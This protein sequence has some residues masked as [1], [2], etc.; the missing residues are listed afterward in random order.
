M[1]SRR[2]KIIFIIS[3]FLVII[4]TVYSCDG[5]FPTAPHDILLPDHTL[6]LNGVFHK[7][8]GKPRIQIEDCY[9][10]H[11]EDLNGMVIIY[12]GEKRWTPSCYQCHGPLWKREGGDNFKNKK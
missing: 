12:N 7:D 4:I 9:E 2:Y 1:V 5:I 8:T 11:S 6:N 3:F 10:C